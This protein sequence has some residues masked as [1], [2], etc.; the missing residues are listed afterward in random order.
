EACC[1]TPRRGESHPGESQDGR[2]GGHAH[3]RGNPAR[4][5][6]RGIAGGATVSSAVKLIGWSRPCGFFT[7]DASECDMIPTNE[8][9]G[10]QCVYADTPPSPSPSSR[11]EAAHVE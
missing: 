3:R 2:R 4:A 7:F 1:S 11:G 5:R 9:G 10:E 6:G 8:H